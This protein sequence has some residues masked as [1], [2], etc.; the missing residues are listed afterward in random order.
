MGAGATPARVAGL[1]PPRKTVEGAPAPR[2]PETA[3]AAPVAAAARVER[4]TIG[5]APGRKAGQ[6]DPLVP[7]RQMATAETGIARL[8]IMAVAPPAEPKHREAVPAALGKRPPEAPR[9]T[10]LQEDDGGVAERARGRATGRRLRPPRRLLDQA[11]RAGPLEPRPKQVRVAA[12][13]EGGARPAIA[14]LAGRPVVPRRAGRRRHQLRRRARVAPER[15]AVA[16]LRA[17][18]PKRPRAAVVATR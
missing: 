14:G 13:A 4:A 17:A 9:K 6:K 18:P 2:P 10:H 15:P 5:P 8:P 7:R 12:E 16:I 3:I 11:V 1:D